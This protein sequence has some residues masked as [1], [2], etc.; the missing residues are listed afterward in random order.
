[1]KNIFKTLLFSVIVATFLSCEDVVDVN[2]D[3]SNP[4]LVIEADIKWQKGTSGNLQ[5][6]KLSMSSSYYES[7]IK[8]ASNAVVTITDATTTYNFI[9]NAGTGD[10][11][12]TNFNPVVNQNYTLTVVY[13]GQTYISSDK[14]YETPTIDSVEQSVL[15]GFGQDNV[16]VKFFYQD[17]GLEN[18]SYL[19]S[20]KNSTALL[21]EYGIVEDTFFQG[22]QMFGLYVSEDL[23]PSNALFMSVQ[24]VS[25]RYANYMTKLLNIAGSSSGSPFSTAPATLRGN[26]TNQTNP[27]DFPF[28]YFNLSEIDSRTYTIQ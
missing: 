6:I 19:I 15:P 22:N 1:M 9:E 16:Q 21:P 7:Q 23:K 11:V 5:T 2:L 4:K 28:G 13:Q 3:T 18:N 25:K 27:D 26:I 10:Y 17:N 8:V 14:L 12:C 24:G 20:F